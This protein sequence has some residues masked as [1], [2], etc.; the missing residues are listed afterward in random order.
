VKGRRSEDG[1]VKKEE[2]ERDAIEGGGT[3]HEAS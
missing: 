2:E 3:F 1:E